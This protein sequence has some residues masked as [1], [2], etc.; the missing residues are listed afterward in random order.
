M[1]R[2]KLCTYIILFFVCFS[3][4]SLA[5]PNQIHANNTEKQYPN[6]TNAN[7]SDAN[8]IP[9]KENKLEST[10]RAYSKHLIL[11][12]IPGLSYAD[13]PVMFSEIPVDI[14]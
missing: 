3:Y 12:L 14:Q 4:I 1:N 8:Q 6:Q 5:L 13:I 11:V 2:T 7:K 9:T 10:G